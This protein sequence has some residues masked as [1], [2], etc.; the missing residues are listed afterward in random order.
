[1]EIKVDANVVEQAVAEAIVK[2]AIGAKI[3]AAV[4]GLLSKSWNNPIDDALEKVIAEVALKC[5]RE[6]YGDLIRAKV[7]E[8]MADECLDNFVQKL[9][10]KV[11]EQ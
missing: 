4:A 11:L 6:E 8:K 2:S 9:W 5:I 1:M 10:D 7:K 3:Q